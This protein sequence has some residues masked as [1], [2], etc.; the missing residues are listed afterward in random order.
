MK[1]PKNIFE[2]ISEPIVSGRTLAAV[3][4]GAAAA[5]AVPL[6]VA[7]AGF[8]TA[9]VAAGSLAAMLQVLACTCIILLFIIIDND[10][11]V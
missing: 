4:A 3:G 10:K 1:Q 8:T 6:A 9:G 5:V 11:I 7:G 2:L